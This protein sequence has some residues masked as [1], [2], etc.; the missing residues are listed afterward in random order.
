MARLSVALG[1]AALVVLAGCYNPKINEG[2]FLCGPNGACPAGFK[3]APDNRCYRNVPPSDGG[4]D[5]PRDVGGGS[6]VIAA[7]G[8]MCQ[9]GLSCSMGAAPN[10]CDPVCQTGCACDS[11]CAFV[12]G[13]PTCAL[14]PPRPADF[15]ESCIPAADNCRAGAVCA[16][17][18][19]PQACG[20]HC[21]RTCREDSDCGGTGRCTEQYLGPNDEFLTKLCGPKI[22]PCNP[23][24]AA[25]E[26]TGASATN[27]PFPS[28]ACYILDAGR[29]DAAG[30]DCAGTIEVG[31]P[32]SARHSCRPG[33]ECLPDAQGTTICRRLC[34]LE[35]SGLPRV[36][37]LGTNALCRPI[38]NSTKYGACL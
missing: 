35:G 12:A 30:C 13:K 15:Y 26:C 24:G 34:T 7:D 14:L 31:Q 23:T 29:D 37:C 5:L 1:L 28:F 19:R 6:D 38:G 11:K 25:P 2:D 8:G 10:Q 36:G 22:E 4:T 17:E 33:A 21:Y 3:C 18:A 32:C 20:A 27:H 16:V 9:R